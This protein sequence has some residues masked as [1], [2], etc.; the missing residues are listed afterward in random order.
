MG[1]Y[2]FA[3]SGSSCCDVGSGVGKNW[4]LKKMPIQLGIFL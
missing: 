2:G 3:N 4:F 1:G